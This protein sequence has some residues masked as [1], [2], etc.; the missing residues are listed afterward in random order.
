[1]ADEGRVT[2]QRAKLALQRFINSHFLTGEAARFSVPVNPDDDDVVLA[3]FIE[4]SEPVSSEADSRSAT[5]TEETMNCTRCEKPIKP[6]QPYAR[7]KRGPHH[8]HEADCVKDAD[9]VALQRGVEAAAI[10]AKYECRL[11]YQRHVGVSCYWH[12]HGKTFSD[13]R[14][15][16]RTFTLSDGR[17]GCGECCN[18]DHCDDASHV[19]RDNC[20]FCLGSGFVEARAA[21]SVGAAQDDWLN[22]ELWNFVNGLLADLDLQPNENKDMIHR[23]M[24]TV[25]KIYAGLAAGSLSDPQIAPEKLSKLSN[26]T[27]DCGR[28]LLVEGQVIGKELGSLSDPWVAGWEA[29]REAAA[30][31]AYKWAASESCDNHSDDPC[32]HVRTGATISQEIRALPAPPSAAQEEK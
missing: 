20:P 18:G 28:K 3:N 5:P 22:G 13:K 1:M 11:C 10:L 24:V 14:S 27:C 2:A 15:N 6:K 30:I 8:V 9:P 16:G 25:C 17:L 12:A 21:G 7:T 32:C 29:G 4:Q 19:S 23:S 31:I 26:F